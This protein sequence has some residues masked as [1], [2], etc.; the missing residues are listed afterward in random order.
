MVETAELNNY[1]VKNSYLNG[2]LIHVGNQSVFEHLAE[3]S[4]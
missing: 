3:I 1:I 2:F 4:F